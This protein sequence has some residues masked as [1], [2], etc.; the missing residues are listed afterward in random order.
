MK[1]QIGDLVIGKITSVKPY[2]LFLS[3]ENGNNGLLHISE[4][5]DSYIRDIEKFGSV[6][7]EIKVKI[8]SID[9]E[10]GFLRL[11]YKKVPEEDRY[12]TH[13]NESRIYLEEKEKDFSE[14]ERRLPIW[15]KE[16]LDKV[17]EK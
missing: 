10:N 17:K 13:V 1:Y 12:S 4:L 6:G 15:I 9:E 8:I 3:F 16:T 2:A 5:S 11:S 7:D 14:L